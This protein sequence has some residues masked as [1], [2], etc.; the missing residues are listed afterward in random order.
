MGT[1]HL[2]VP[3]PDTDEEETFDP[4]PDTGEDREGDVAE[5]QGVA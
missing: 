2:P 4:E 3:L 5:D 1:T